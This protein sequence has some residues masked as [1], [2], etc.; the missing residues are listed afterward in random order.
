[1][2]KTIKT[3]DLIAYLGGEIGAYEA[4][5]ERYS[6]ELDAI[7]KGEYKGHRP[8]E[9]EKARLNAHLLYMEHQIDALGRVK[10]DIYY[11]LAKEDE[12]E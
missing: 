9:A 5:S 4:A 11:K 6:R 7:D 1:M 10:R 12:K 2:K 8:I 3:A